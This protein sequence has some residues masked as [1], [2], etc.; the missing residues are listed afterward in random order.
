MRSEFWLE[1]CCDFHIIPF[2]HVKNI[3][4]VHNAALTWN[5][6]DGRQ[7]VE[8]QETEQEKTN[9]RSDGAAGWQNNTHVFAF[10]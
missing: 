7:Q 1:F 4:F 8:E 6:T 10:E 5:Q 2:Y 3:A 9:K